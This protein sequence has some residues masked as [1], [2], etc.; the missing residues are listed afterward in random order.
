MH[1]QLKTYLKDGQVIDNSY[2]LVS[3]ESDTLPAGDILVAA[4]YWQ[5]NQQ[6]LSEHSGNVGVWIDSHEEIEEFAST[7]AA[8]PVIAINFPKFVDGRGFS[9]ARLLR[10]RYGYIGEI[11]AIGNFIRDQLFMMQRCGFNAFQFESEIDMAAASQSLN[12]FSD[13]YQVAVDQPEPLFKRHR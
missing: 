2:Q 8:A 6:Q 11:R 12:D 13:S 9:V 1:Q 10:E 3:A 7:I 5:A 4:A